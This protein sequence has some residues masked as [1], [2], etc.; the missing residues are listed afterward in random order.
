MSGQAGRGANEDIEIG[1]LDPRRRAT[2]L[3]SQAE[4]LRQR[5]DTL[6]DEIAR[7]HR[8]SPGELM[9]RYAVPA[10]C[11]LIV[12][13]AGLLLFLDWRRR[14]REVWVRLGSGSQSQL[15]RLLS[16]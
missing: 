1:E 12:A 15:R 4:E 16:S 2:L 11:T 10:A 7:H 9:R 6:L 14:R 3:E 13:G 8:R 5:L